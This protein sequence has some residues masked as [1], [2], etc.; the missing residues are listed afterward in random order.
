[1]TRVLTP[2]K[3]KGLS[4]LTI[5]GERGGGERWNATPPQFFFTYVCKRNLYQH[6]PFSVFNPDTFLTKFG[7][8]SF[9]RHK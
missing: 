1:M 7:E 3:A 9:L 2:N 6:L 8:D 4:R 5:G